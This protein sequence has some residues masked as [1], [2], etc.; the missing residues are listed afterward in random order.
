MIGGDGGVAAI[1]SESGCLMTFFLPSYLDL[2]R[3]HACGLDPPRRPSS[4]SRWDLSVMGKLSL[5]HQIVGGRDVEKSAEP[6]QTL[7]G[8]DSDRGGLQ[9]KQPE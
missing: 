5:G 7:T 1:L 6:K 2:L 9:L 8:R 3:E 4:L